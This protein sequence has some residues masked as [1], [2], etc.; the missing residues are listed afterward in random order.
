[1]Y[2]GRDV[3]VFLTMPGLKNLENHQA[4]EILTHFTRTHVQDAP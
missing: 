4:E 1:M 3:N 2:G